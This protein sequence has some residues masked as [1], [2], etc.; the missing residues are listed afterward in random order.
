MPVMDGLE[1][2]QK[3][4]TDTA[5][6]HIPVVML[7]A[8]N[9]DDQRIEGYEHGAD[10]YITKPF[11]S[12]L[13]MVR[14]DNLLKERTRLRSIFNMNAS[15]EKAFAEGDR[16]FIGKLRLIIMDNIGNSDFKVE[17]IGQQVGLSRA[18]LYRKVKIN[19]SKR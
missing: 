8:K 18:Q 14:I 17:M 5:T 19:M 4:K 3:L 9:L 7:T 12:K 2:C 16:T 6:S 15:Q 13:L 11:N 1:C 10:A